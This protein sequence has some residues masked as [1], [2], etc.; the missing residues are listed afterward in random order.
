MLYSDWLASPQRLSPK[1]GYI[2]ETIK[3]KSTHILMP[4]RLVILTK[5]CFD[6]SIYW[7]RSTFAD[8]TLVNSTGAIFQCPVTW[9]RIEHALLVLFCRKPE[10][11]L[12]WR[13]NGG[14]VLPIFMAFVDFDVFWSKDHVHWNKT[15]FPSVIFLSFFAWIG[16][17][18]SSEKLIVW[19]LFLTHQLL[20]GL[21]T[22][23]AHMA[24]VLLQDIST[25]R[26]L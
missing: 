6:L 17:Y 18:V 12:W 22:A 25:K 13:E 16:E 2:Y 14:S 11:F 15:R 26:S 24:V 3:T 8:F 19:C 20:I 23:P 7:S 9:P 5:S 21:P 1:K 4:R 10:G